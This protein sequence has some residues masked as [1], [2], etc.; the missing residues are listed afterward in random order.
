MSDR[1][2]NADVAAAAAGSPPPRDGNGQA[3]AQRLLAT[4]ETA[5]NRLSTAYELDTALH[6]TVHGAVDAIPGAER[7]GI[8]EV[9]SDGTITSLAPSDDQVDA[10]DRLQ[11]KLAEGPCLDAITADRTIWVSDLT[12]ETTRWSRFAPRAIELG[13]ASVLSFR[14][15]TESRPLTALNLYAATPAAFDENAQLLGELFASHAAIAVAHAR[16]AAEL[17]VALTN[18]DVI[19][20][21]KGILME[22]FD[23][24]AYEAFTMLVE[25]SQRSNLK[26]A[27]IAQW[28]TGNTDELE[29]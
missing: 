9:T 27:A 8:S 26:L 28:L 10:L 19:G 6:T 3:A 14:L 20:Q 7:G 1:D 25:S 2:S 16:N 24:N 11:T 4:L 23:I 12:S 17:G 22:R 15:T 21:A 13:A 18:R 5:G 29:G